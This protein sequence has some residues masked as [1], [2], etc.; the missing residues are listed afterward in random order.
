M[1][2]A[3]KLYTTCW[4]R[5]FAFFPK[6]VRVVKYEPHAPQ[7]IIGDDVIILPRVFGVDPYTLAPGSYST[8]KNPHALIW[9]EPYYTFYGAV[10]EKVCHVIPI[11]RAD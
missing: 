4:V 7:N 5:R 10:G 11:T 9:L 8:P 6:V 3:E 1:I 2:L